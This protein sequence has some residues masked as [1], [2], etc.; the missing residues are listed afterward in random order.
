MASRRVMYINA[1]TFVSEGR[2]RNPEESL[3]ASAKA[4][5]WIGS[6]A[7]IVTG[8]GALLAWLWP[9]P[10][11]HLAYRGVNFESRKSGGVWTA[12]YAHNGEMF[13]VNGTTR[14]DLLAHVHEQIDAL[15]APGLVVAK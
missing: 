12:R 1:H 5:L 15:L 14:D 6:I 3:S 4:A 13:S 10:I 8:G 11:E 9:Q 2:R 7:T